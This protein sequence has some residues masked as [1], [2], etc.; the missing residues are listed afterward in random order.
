MAW[1]KTFLL[2]VLVLTTAVAGALFA[3]QNTTPVALD[4]LVLQLPARTVSLWILLALALGVIL[5][6]SAGAVVMLSLRAR[7]RTLSRQ[8]QRLALEVDRLRRVGLAD[9]E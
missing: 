1:L 9:S 8:K 5:G 7:L 3:L 6:L 4:L 2:L